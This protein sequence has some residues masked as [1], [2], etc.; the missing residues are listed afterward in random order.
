MLLAI[1]GYAQ[2]APET[3]PEIRQVAGKQLRGIGRSRR[4]SSGGSSGTSR[5]GSGFLGGFFGGGDS[6][7]ATEQDD[8][9]RKVTPIPPE[10]PADWSGV[11]YHTA[12]APPTRR[13]A[14]PIRDSAVISSQRGGQSA[15]SRPV[16]G[17]SSRPD[18]SPRPPEIARESKY[19]VP[20]PPPIDRLSRATE[21]T[22]PRVIGRRAPQPIAASGSSRRQ[23]PEDRSA[24]ASQAVRTVP[25]PLRRVEADDQPVVEL[26]PKVSRRRIAA[27]PPAATNES[28]STDMPA[29]RSRA[30]SVAPSARRSIAPTT[31]AIASAPS[32]QPA[33][34][35]RPAAAEVPSQR[36]AAAEVAATPPAAAPAE[37]LVADVPKPLSRVPRRDLSTKSTPV[38]TPTAPPNAGFVARGTVSSPAATAPDTFT[39]SVP[40]FGVDAKTAAISIAAKTSAPASKAPAAASKTLAPA[41]KTPAAAGAPLLTSATNM[42]SPPATSGRSTAEPE[43]ELSS[44]APAKTLAETTVIDGQDVHN[45]DSANRSSDSSAAPGL[46]VSAIGPARVVVGQTYPYTVRVENAGTIAANGVV[47]QIDPARWAKIVGSRAATGKVAGADQTAEPILWQIDDIAAGAAAELQLLIQARHGG[48]HQLDLAWTLQPRPQQIQ[49]TVTEPKLKVEITGP[50]KVIYGQSKTYRIRVLN[51]GDGP[52]RNVVFTLSPESPGAQSQPIGDIP[53]GREA[54]FEVELTAQDR[55]ELKI[56]GVA[57]GDL[58]LTAET[59]K[60]VQVLLADLHAELSGPEIRYQNKPA[61]YQLVVSNDGTAASREV[62][63]SLQ[64]PEGVEYLGGLDQAKVDGRRLSWTIQEIG[65][66]DERTFGFRCQLTQAGRQ[67][68]RVSARGTALGETSVSL[69]TNVEAIADLVLT[70]ED[71]AAPAPTGRQV[72]YDLVIRNRGSLPASAVQAVAQF[73]HGIEPQSIVGHA[74]RVVPGQVLIEPID[75]IAPGQEVRIGIEAIA[76]QAGHHRFRAEVRSGDTIL[77]AEEATRFMDIS[78]QRISRRSDAQTTKPAS[79][80]PPRSAAGGMAFPVR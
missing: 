10:E 57:A 60:I 35:Q 29:E 42:A 34:S 50:D 74:G 70:V 20:T 44:D 41:S 7:A 68:F 25:E 52:A 78:N 59:Q 11:P 31:S 9:Y 73:S 72:R 26:V 63:V 38:V 58:E 71:P 14:L 39:P 28:R 46:R 3:H 18:S 23:V 62:A 80:S 17:S 51:P 40:N 65:S 33:P 5:S 55:G 56:H 1:P 54:Q 8:E 19:A 67:E 13:S 66:H 21:A 77:V 2:T 53:S 49:V 48:D 4:N 43:D 12:T 47:V 22:A 45:V 69:A 36:P 32:R 30:E 16:G 6:A 76:A 75:N 15:A 61:D 79:Q 64:L 27:L 37:K 24:S